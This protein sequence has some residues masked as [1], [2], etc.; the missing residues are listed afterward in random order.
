MNKADNHNYHEAFEKLN[1]AQRE[2]V[3]TIEGAVMGLAVPGTGKTQVLG[4]RIGYI[5]DNT[6]TQAHNILCLTFTD[7]GVVAMRER[8]IKFIDKDAYKV[9]IHTF[10]SFCNKVIQENPQYFGYRH[11]IKVASD[12]QKI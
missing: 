9:N 7:A 1:T 11:D 10:H 6:D 12:I 8:L 2:A 5:L 3:T 4:T